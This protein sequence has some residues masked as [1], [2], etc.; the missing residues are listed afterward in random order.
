MTR[1]RCSV[2]KDYDLCQKCLEAEKIKILKSLNHAHLFKEWATTSNEEC[3]GIHLFGKCKSDN[4]E[5]RQLFKCV[6]DC[7]GCLY[8]CRNCIEEPLRKKYI[9]SHHKHP[10]LEYFYLSESHRCYGNYIFGEC[11][12]VLNKT[13]IELKY[14]FEDCY[15]F[16][17]CL[18]CFN[19]PK[20]I[21]YKSMNHKHS[22]VQVTK[23]N[24]TDICCGKYLF[25]ECKSS[26]Q[27]IKT[28]YKC[29]QCSDNN[30]VD[31]KYFG[32]EDY[33]LCELCLKEPETEK[34][35]TQYHDHAFR[36]YFHTGN[37]KCKG[38]GE[39]L[40]SHQCKLSLDQSKLKYEYSRYMCVECYKFNL[41]DGCINEKYKINQE[42]IPDLSF[43]FH[44]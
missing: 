41:C 40:D 44:E 17:L 11:K 35:F 12:S 15:G 18:Q 31:K 38:I 5:T 24:D 36:K 28:F 4:D 13:K 30:Y 43:L 10:L 14:Y 21:K 16:N 42:N 8:L 25:G 22:L 27:E 26:E 7:V 1:Y 2:C 34:Y 39:N 19:S 6:E 20:P 32:F 37:W 29:I 3:Y 9:S 33:L 23:K